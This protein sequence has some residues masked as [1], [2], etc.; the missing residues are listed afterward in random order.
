VS[1]TRICTSNGAVRERT[2]FVAK[3][4]WSTTRFWSDGTLVAGIDF[5]PVGSVI[6]PSGPC[7]PDTAWLCAVSRL[8]SPAPFRAITRARIVF[9]TSPSRS[10]YASSEKPDWMMQLFPAP[11]QRSQRNVNVIGW[12]P[13]HVPGATCRVW[14]CAGV[15]L[16]VGAATFTGRPA[17]GCRTR[18]VAFDVAACEPSA[19]VAV[20]RTRSRWSTSEA[21]TTYFAVVAPPIAAQSEPSGRPPSAA[22]RSHW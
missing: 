10:T 8:V 14:P 3:R 7:G 20:T 13:F 2:G 21:A 4:T 17:S 6:T 1:F 15:P 16:S 18:A 22:H 12:R 11:S 9:P 5:S 19:F